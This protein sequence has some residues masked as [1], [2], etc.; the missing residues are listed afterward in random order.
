MKTNLK[1]PCRFCNIEQGG[2]QKRGKHEETCPNRISQLKASQ[3]ATKAALEERY[4]APSLQCQG[5][6]RCHNH[7]EAN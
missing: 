2:R 5:N 1:W 7:Q 4:C 6:Y 3:A